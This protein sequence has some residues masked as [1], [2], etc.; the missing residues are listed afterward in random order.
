MSLLVCG[1]IKDIG[2]PEI[3]NFKKQ[4]Y[5]AG[6]Q[7][8]QIEKNSKNFI[9]Y[10]NNDG[11]LEY[12]GSHWQLY[13]LPDPSVVRSLKIDANDRIYTG[14][15]NEFGYLEPDASGLLSYH[16]LSEQLGEESQNFDEIWRIHITSF[17]VVFQSY[18]H[19]FIYRDEKLIE[20]PLKNRIRFSFY[21]K[22]RLWI[23]DEVDGLM[24]YQQGQL[25]KI[26]GVESLRD[27]EIWSILPLSGTKILIGT[28][29]HG[30]F[31]Y[32]GS[33][34][35]PWENEANQF[36]KQNQIFSGCKVNQDYM[37]F[38]TIQN[39]LMI[40][41]ESG[42]IIQH[43]NKK[44]GL[45][46][47]TI[48]SIGTDWDQNLWLGL[49]N[50]IDY[51][52]I[53]SPFT[54]IYDPEGLGATYT[55]IIHQGK[56]Y[57]GTNHGL[58]VKDWPEKATISP[59]GFRLVRGTIGQTWYLGVHQGNLLMG[60]N[61]GAYLIEGDSARQISP[62]EG[63]WTFTE[64][65]DHPDA[66]IGGNYKGLTLF[67][68]TAD[69]QSWKFVDTI[70]G[71]TESS[72]LLAEGTD[73]KLWMSHG[74]KGVYKMTLS[75]SLDKVLNYHYYNS[76]NGLPTDNFIN[77]MAVDNGLIYTS[78]NGIYTYNEETDSF[79]PSAY[80]DELFGNQQ[81]V[82]YIL[83]DDYHNL[84]YTATDGPGVLRFQEDGTY[85]KV[86]APFTKLSGRLI[87]GFQHIYV[88]DPLNTFIA[89]ENGLAH[90]TPRY[91]N[92]PDTLFKTFIREVV[93]IPEDKTWY[94]ANIS[95]PTDIPQYPFK[96]NN[97][98]FTY[99]CPNYA[100]QRNI[101]FNYQLKNYHADWTGWTES[102][103]C[104]FMNLHEG[105][106]TF[107]VKA[108]LKSGSE[109]NV[110]QFTFIILPPWYRRSLAYFAYTLIGL[111]LILLAFWLVY[112]RIQVSKR[113]ERLKNLQIYR[114]QIQQYQRE[115][116][117][118]EK[119]IIR[120]RNEK[121]RGKMIHRDK[122]LANQTMNIIQKNKFMG[123]LKSELKKLQ[124]DSN[125]ASIKSRI[126][127]IINRIDKEFDNK[128][129]NELFETYFDEVHEDFFHRLSE[130]YP[131]LT[132]RE[133]K[134]CAY[135]KMNISS[136]EIA[137]LLNIS[138]RGVEISRYRLRKKMN[139][140][141]TTNLSALIAGI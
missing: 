122:E 96:G 88:A 54:F 40:T 121:L 78:P 18:T 9:Y 137:T 87:S 98:K 46:N 25:V 86:S 53:N 23:Q 15:Q 42:K 100:N 43:V 64:L 34:L 113:K 8:W 112:R 80:Y 35:T 92:R 127:L 99:A 124:E 101:Q 105:T 17:G 132:P 28:A 94:A 16:S 110:D 90:Y 135:I 7:N 126:S 136:K 131:T 102:S 52:D 49:D 128:K 19:L 6:A 26:A 119:E 10:A 75:D 60:H 117:I 97:L 106:Y 31:V 133:M 93:N 59:K 33:V 139:V 41:D 134:L 120:L 95:E 74:Y 114:N 24:E 32:D 22:G 4:D 29:N 58:F 141:R 82:N 39:G 111:A 69:G 47:N 50:G 20:V 62:I 91:T 83:E 65:A 13:G 76:Q 55:S 38:G 67:K 109:T 71:F 138:V 85:S 89:L 77:L 118:S 108:R 140:D 115:A 79:E 2:I 36:L 30:V 66:L 45:Q 5:R 123:K 116:L 61:N 63:A 51:L 104:Q 130:K 57:V 103:E 27:Y 73:G 1:Q 125:N 56:L 21:L 3:V 84:W 68:R 48:L 11:L 44:K 14:Q 129:Q 37:A 72:R 70:E 107:Q 81:S 12:D